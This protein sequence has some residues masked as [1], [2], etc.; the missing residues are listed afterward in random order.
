MLT[1]KMCTVARPMGM[2]GL[3]NMSTAVPITCKAAVARGVNDLRIET[4]TVD[5]PKVGEV[6]L[7]VHSNA[8]CHTDIY[9]LIGSIHGLLG[10]CGSP[11]LPATAAVAQALCLSPSP[12][13]EL[14]VCEGRLLPA[15]R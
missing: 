14:E 3:R 6:R 11:L 12:S 13:L 15:L 8:L 5:P 7:K 4:I 10:R 2:A 9:T 1:C